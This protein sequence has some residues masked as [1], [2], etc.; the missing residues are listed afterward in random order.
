[1]KFVQ[2]LLNFDQK[3]C[4]EGINE[5]VLNGIIDES[6]LVKK[7]KT[8]LA[9]ATVNK[10][11]ETHKNMKIRTR[12]EVNASSPEEPKAIRIYAYQKCFQD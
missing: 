4:R 1:M 11:K 2:K 3:N 6:D 10:T 7:V 9:P 12:E 5:E 8:D